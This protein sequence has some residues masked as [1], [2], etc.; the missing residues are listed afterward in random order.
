MPIETSRLMIRDFEMN[1]WPAVHRYGS[2]LEIM[3]DAIYHANNETDTKN[4]VHQAIISAKQVP[5]TIYERAGV[6][7]NNGPGRRIDKRDISDPHIF[8][9]FEQQQV[10][11]AVLCWKG[12]HERFA[13]GF[14]TPWVAD[15]I[16]VVMVT[17]TPF[18][19]SLSVDNTR[20]FD[21]DMLEVLPVQQSFFIVRTHIF[22]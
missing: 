15:D 2:D 12:A 4:F 16:P 10:A 18:I 5:K 22:G 17:E 21:G 6:L 1:D 19:F 3:K 8:T 20:A 14:H 9:A 7:R 13:Q 11:D